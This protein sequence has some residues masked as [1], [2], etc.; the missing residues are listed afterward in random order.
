M[1]QESQKVE[2]VCVSFISDDKHVFRLLLWGILLVTEVFIYS[3]Y[4]ILA[5]LCLVEGTLPFRSSSVVFSTEVLKIVLSI[6]MMLP[7]LGR[8]DIKMPPLSNCIPFVVPAVLYCINNNLSVYMQVQMDPTTY[9]ILGNMKVA[10]TAILYRII[11]QRKLSS[12]QWISLGVL[13]ISGILDSYG[14]M[15]NK[16]S[17]SSG[18]IRL[19]VTGLLMMCAYCWISG[20]AG[21]YTE[22][23]LKKQYETSLHVQNTLLYTFGIVLNGG[24]WALQEAVS[25]KEGER[26]LNLFEG[27]TFKTWV[28]VVSLAFN[29]LIMSA[30]M[31]HGSNITRLFIIS[32]AML[33]TTLLSVAIFH[34]ALN[35]YYILAF[36]SV[37]VAL[38][39]YHR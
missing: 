37:V 12:V 17:V 39:M 2:S 35:M 15:Q 19:T 28:I 25:G 16:A 38:Y 20:L 27:F 18:E 14:G 24:V 1:A 33:V 5:H 31:K 4:T 29:G 13:S 30:I 22:Y 7:E 21:V 26:R 6:A 36:I 8:G 32:C 23:I 10:S 11:M 34:L 9:Q 3:S